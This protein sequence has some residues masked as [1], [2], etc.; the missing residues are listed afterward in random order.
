M[1]GFVGNVVVFPQ[2][3]GGRVLRSLPPDRLTIAE[4]LSIVF[5]GSEEDYKRAKVE[6]LGVSLEEFRA[7]YE[8]FRSHNEQY[9]RVS[10]DDVA[11]RDLEGDAGALGLPS[12]LAQCVR[13]VDAEGQ[14]TQVTRQRGPA[15]AV[16]P[17]VGEGVAEGEERSV[18]RKGGGGTTGLLGGARETG[19]SDTGEAGAHG[20]CGPS[21][22]GHGG[23][24]KERGDSATR[25]KPGVSCVVDGGK[26]CGE[27]VDVGS[28][29]GE[30]AR[31]EE[32]GGLVEGREEEEEWNVA[33]ADVDMQTDHDKQFKAVEISLRRWE[34][35]AAQIARE[36]AKVRSSDRA[37]LGE[38]RSEGG[39]EQ[40]RLDAMLLEQALKKLDVKRMESDLHSA[41]QALERT[42]AVPGQQ[43]EGALADLRVT[44]KGQVFLDVPT[45]SAPVSMFDPSF[46]SAFDPRSFPYGDGVYGLEREAPVTYDE[47]CRCL[48][49]REELEYSSTF[50]AVVCPGRRQEGTC[51]RSADDDGGRAR[52]LAAEACPIEVYSCVSAALRLCL[53]MERH[54]GSWGEEA[55]VQRMMERKLL[56]DILSKL[57]AERGLVAKQVLRGALLHMSEEGFLR[58]REGEGGQVFV[59]VDPLPRWRSARDLQTVMYCLWR[60]RAYI[61]SG[62]L[63]ARKQKWH[64]ALKDIGRLQASEMY[65]TCELLGKGQGLKDALAHP[66][67]PERVKRAMRALLLCMSSNVG[68]NAHRTMLR[69]VN[70]SY[71]LLFG[72]PLVF[73]TPNVSDTKNPIM[74][75]MYMGQ[76]V[77]SWRLLE[78]EAPEMPSAEEM[79]RRVARDPVSQ[80][81]FFHMMVMLFLEHVLGV[82]VQGVAAD[83]VASAW[84]AGLFGTVVAY[85]GPVET[86]GRGGLHP[87]M[88][89]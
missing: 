41:Q 64:E 83:G 14:T 74:N 86:Q 66:E 6:Q 17:A 15:E 58:R 49:Q 34:L 20:V 30:V 46:W 57:V 4:H 7:A 51:G 79:L 67:V 50:D 76:C 53:G 31:E 73:T 19:A 22:N 21:G 45:A 52:R 85:F 36:E 38:Y 25:T 12:L 87:H 70:V 10:W 8:W 1:K 80:A 48:L 9:A 54:D 2:A 61:Q 63:F 69:H 3:D 89:V 62:R 44:R 60:R 16:E 72:A 13:R 42:R 11:A 35:R 71:K 5:R 78:A 59:L 27:G 43:V 81:Q 47:W 82:D 65:M 56:A 68:S 88:H 24:E 75:L 33:V 26:G 40:L 37:K 28:E 18:R 84:G 55:L 23:S 29:D 32:R 39:R 77:N